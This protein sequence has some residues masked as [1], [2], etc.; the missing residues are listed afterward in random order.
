[1]NEIN[2]QIAERISYR[3]F[4]G[5]RALTFYKFIKLACRMTVFP[6]RTYRVPIDQFS[7]IDL[8]G[9][10]LLDVLKVL[11]YGLWHFIHGATMVYLD[12]IV[13]PSQ[14][15]VAH[16]KAKAQYDSLVSWKPHHW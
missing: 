11:R 15:S 1:M 5:H 10:T 13:P 14:W 9:N 4:R 6:N 2:Q 12:E 8:P 3:F 7:K 16:S